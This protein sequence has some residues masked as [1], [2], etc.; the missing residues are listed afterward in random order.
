MSRQLF[1]RPRPA[2]VLATALALCAVPAAHADILYDGFGS[3][4]GLTLNG[5]AASASTGDGNVLRLTPALGDRAG[6]AFSTAKVSTA[7]FT[8]V[9]SFRITSPA[10]AVF[11][12]NNEPGADGIV[13]VVQNVANNVGGLGQG[14]GYQGIGSSIGVEFDTWGNAGNLDP[15]QSHVGIDLNGVVVHNAANGPTVNVTGPELD[16]GHRWWSW[17]LYDQ[18]KLDVYLLRSD[19]ATEPAIPASPILTHNVDLTATLGGQPQA[20]VGFTS[21]TG[22]AWENHDVLY[23]RYT[24]AV[25]EPG[26]ASVAAAACVLALARRRR[27]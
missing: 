12:N 20:F 8:S 2:F 15:S 23:W 21:A 7:K 3:I 25:P 11:D 13:M 22:A 1:G 26:T 19:S 24:E 10:G 5:S 27:V 17:V 6:S 14:I 4:A 18:N 9:F 16:D